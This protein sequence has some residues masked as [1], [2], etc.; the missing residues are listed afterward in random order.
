MTRLASTSPSKGRPA[1]STVFSRFDASSRPRC[2]PRAPSRHERQPGGA[3]DGLDRLRV[4]AALLDH[5]LERVRGSPRS[6]RST[7][8]RTRRS[9]S[10]ARRSSSSGTPSSRRRVQQ[11]LARGA[12]LA[13]EPFEQVVLGHHPP[14]VPVP[15]AC[16]HPARRGE[17]RPMIVLGIDPGVANTGYGVVRRAAAGRLVALDGGVIETPSTAAARG[18]AGVDLR[19]DRGAARRARARR[20]RARGPLL[21]RQRPLGVR[22]RPGARRRDARRRPARDRLRVATRPSR[23]RARCAAAA[24]RPRTR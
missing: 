21:R 8:S 17:S 14:C 15:A 23:S 24:A 3:A 5:L 20:R 2:T 4:D 9:S 13:L 7:G 11:P 12:G 22:G 18:P 1:S 19:A 10:T 16:R 6:R